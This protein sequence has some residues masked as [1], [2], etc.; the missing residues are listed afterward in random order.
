MIYLMQFSAAAFAVAQ[1]SVNSHK[2][3]STIHSV[4][5]DRHKKIVMEKAS[6]LY[7]VFDSQSSMAENLLLTVPD[8]YFEPRNVPREARTRL[9][10]RT[11]CVPGVL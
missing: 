11:M 6:R 9:E 10:E 3:K 1:D 8:C 4:L 5:H 7:I 2:F